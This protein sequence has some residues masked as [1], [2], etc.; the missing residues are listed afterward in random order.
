M[1]NLM[2]TAVNEIHRVLLE[3]AGRCVAD[4]LLPAAPIPAFAV[5]VPAERSHG[6]SLQTSL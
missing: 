4:G 3:A 1:L 5:E 6:D 2:N